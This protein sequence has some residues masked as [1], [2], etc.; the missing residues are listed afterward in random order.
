M[1]V[2]SN[3]EIDDNFKNESVQFIVCGRVKL[4]A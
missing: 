1:N 2:P 3:F 4:F